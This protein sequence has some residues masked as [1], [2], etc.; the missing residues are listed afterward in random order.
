MKP[1]MFVI[2]LVCSLLLFA[3]AVILAAFTMVLLSG[4][5]NAV[6]FTAAG[7]ILAAGAALILAVWGVIKS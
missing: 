4:F 5:G 3:F 7:V 2:R 1:K 6:G